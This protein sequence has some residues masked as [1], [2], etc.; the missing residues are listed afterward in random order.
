[1]DP[2][3]VQIGETEG[4]NSGAFSFLS[5]NKDYIPWQ[6]SRILKKAAHLV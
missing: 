4:Q 5:C 3:T 1:M 2:F 6:R